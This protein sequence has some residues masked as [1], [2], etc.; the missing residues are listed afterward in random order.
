MKDSLIDEKKVLDITRNTIRSIKPAQEAQSEFLT[1]PET[2]IEL[3]ENE[4]THI[5]HKA[6]L[7]VQ[8]DTHQAMEDSY[9]T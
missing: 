9:T 2:D 8:K 7:Q 4:L 5:L 1:A 6:Y 3:S